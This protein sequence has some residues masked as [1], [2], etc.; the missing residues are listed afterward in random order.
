MKIARFEDAPDP[1]QWHWE[2]LTP[3]E[4]KE[5][6]EQRRQVKV[7]G[8]KLTPDVPVMAETKAAAP[9]DGD[10]WGDKLWKTTRNAEAWPKTEPASSSSA[11]ASAQR[12]K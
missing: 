10:W 11:T 6:D 8:K 5:A 12:Q 2:P 3:E 4:E 7:S 9:D 1:S